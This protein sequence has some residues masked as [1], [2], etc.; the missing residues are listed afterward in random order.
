MGCYI[1]GIRAGRYVRPMLSNVICPLVRDKCVEHCRCCLAFLIDCMQELVEDKRG[2]SFASRMCFD[3]KILVQY[4]ADGD[5]ASI[6]EVCCLPN[7]K[8]T[9][10]QDFVC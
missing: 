10:I 2:R 6:V 5:N 7:P 3:C 9:W 4:A 8:V 1:S